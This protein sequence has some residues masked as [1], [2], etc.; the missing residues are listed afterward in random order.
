MVVKPLQKIITI[1][2]YDQDN[3]SRDNPQIASIFSIVFSH[4]LT[5]ISIEPHKHKSLIVFQTIYLMIIQGWLH[6]LNIQG[7]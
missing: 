4:H 3:N 2:R 6:I 7:L 5:V 1:T